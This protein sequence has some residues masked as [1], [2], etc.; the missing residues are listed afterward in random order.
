[1]EIIGSNQVSAT[2]D[3]SVNTSAFGTNP[4]DEPI[5]SASPVIRSE[6]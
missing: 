3:T 2:K 4:A 5:T 1:M 6:P